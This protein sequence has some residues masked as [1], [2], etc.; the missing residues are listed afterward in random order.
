MDGGR[1]DHEDPPARSGGSLVTAVAWTVFGAILIA[2]VVVSTLAFQELR[3]NYRALGR[4]VAEFQDQIRNVE[5][6]FESAEPLPSDAIRPDDP[7]PAPTTWQDEDGATVTN[8]DWLERPSGADLARYY[9]SLAQ[10]LGVQGRAVIECV[11]GVDGR[12]NDCVVIEEAPQGMGFGAATVEIAAHF[13][14]TPQTRDGEPVDGAS[15]RLP[16]QWRLG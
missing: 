5:A 14:M 9:P 4:T 6:G 13:R 16:I 1:N 2:T 7:R 8:P 12:L 15:I 11:V 3:E 10:A